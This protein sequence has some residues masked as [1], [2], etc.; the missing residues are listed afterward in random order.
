M[1]ASQDS[2]LVVSCMTENG[3]LDTLNCAIDENGA[4]TCGTI[5]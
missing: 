4:A 2:L 3:V 1:D 5:Q